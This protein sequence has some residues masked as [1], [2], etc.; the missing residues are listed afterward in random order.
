MPILEW[1]K[2]GERL[3]HTGVKKGVVYPQANGIYPAGYAF[4]G[5]TSFQESPEG[6][7]ANDIYADD[8]KY[9][10]LRSVENF[11]FS[12]G[13]Y[14]YP[15]EFG[16]CLGEV[17][18]AQGVIIGQQPHKPFGFSCVSTI[19]NDTEYENHGYIIHLVYGATAAPSEEEHNTINDSPEATEFSWECETVPPSISG[20][21]PS[22]HIKIDSTKATDEQMAAIEAVL[23]GTEGSV[24]YDVFTGSEFEEGVD[25][26]ERSG[27]EGHYIYTKTLDVEPEI[28][29]TYYTKQ[30]TG[31][32]TARLPLPDEVAYI[33]SN[34]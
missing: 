13:A 5:L 11:K 26:Y 17:E 25:Y 6:A 24:S 7:E 20:H 28:G 31:G 1:D 14:T 16:E 22:A 2:T 30:V 32:T 3:Y 34:A 10:V 33:M 8:I 12:I 19:G 4:N 9:L 18:I 27:T 23:Y 29:K 21:K 15:P